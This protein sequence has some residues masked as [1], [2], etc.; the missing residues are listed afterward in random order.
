MTFLCLKTEKLKYELEN[1]ILY[2]NYLFIGLKMKNLDTLYKAHDNGGYHQKLK[3]QKMSDDDNDKDESLRR[4][5][6][7]F[8]NV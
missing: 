2:R 4:K 1:I 5:S 8:F 3:Q 6:L 7:L